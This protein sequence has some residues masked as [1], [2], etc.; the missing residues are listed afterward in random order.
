MRTLH[1][2]QYQCEV[3]MKHYSDPGVAG[4]CEADCKKQ[5]DCN[6]AMAWHK[7]GSGAAWKVLFR[8]HCKKCSHGE[9]S[10]C[11]IEVTPDTRDKLDETHL[12]VADLI[13]SQNNK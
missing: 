6:H 3:C 11:L 1:L 7:L 9:Y 10:G 8:K 5:K 4:R 2:T 12:A 13:L